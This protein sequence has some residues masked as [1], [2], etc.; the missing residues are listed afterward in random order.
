MKKSAKVNFKSLKPE[1]YLSL[2]KH[3]KGFDSKQI[4]F[5]D[6]KKAIYVSTTSKSQMIYTFNKDSLQQGE[7]FLDLA[8]QE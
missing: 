1:Y 4:V 5:I 3:N 7:E 2:P 8:I 6:N